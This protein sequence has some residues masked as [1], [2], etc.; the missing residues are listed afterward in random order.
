MGSVY[1]HYKNKEAIIDY[2]SYYEFDQMLKRNFPQKTNFLMVK[3][4]LFS[5]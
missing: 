3:E 5:F 1:Y 2:L 4:A